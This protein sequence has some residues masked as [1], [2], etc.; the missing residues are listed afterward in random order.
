MLMPTKNDMYLIILKQL[1]E[2]KQQNK[3]IKKH[4]E[5]KLNLTDKIINEKTDKGNKRLDSRVNWAIKDLELA[6]L[7]EKK[8]RGLANLTEDGFEL[9]KENPTKITEKDLL[10]FEAYREYKKSI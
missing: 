8:E 6:D 4:I 3:D 2:G 10:K 5:K 7:I 1:S 9:L